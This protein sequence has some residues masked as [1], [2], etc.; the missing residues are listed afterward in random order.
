MKQPAVKISIVALAFLVLVSMASTPSY[1]GGENRTGTNAAPELLI[2]VGAR[3]I[4]M[5]GASIA[6]SSGLDAIFWN[7]AGLARAKNAANAMFSHM[8]Y[9]ADIGVDYVAVSGA[10]EGFGSIGLSIKSLSIGDIKVTTEDAPDGTGQVINPTVV[11]I[12][13]T[14]SRLLTDRI[15]V[16]ATATLISNRFDRVSATGFAFNAGVQYSGLAGVSGLSVGVAVKNVGPQMKFDGEGLLRQGN[17]NDVLRPG[18]F[19][20]VNA[21]SFELPS[22]IEIGLSYGVDVAENNVVNLASV[23]QNNNFA[24]DEYKVGAEYAYDNTFFV[25]GGYNFSEKTKNSSLPVPDQT[26]YI[27]GFTAGAGVHYL[28]GS[29]DL[30]LDYAYR[31]V[32]FLDNNHIFT[33]SLGF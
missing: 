10:F 24:A 14:Y 1:A 16:G 30:T 26:T 7:P 5:G 13:L 4:A 18:S 31:Q 2:P 28:V 25:R 23:F 19:Y 33:L 3:D 17:I 12:G 32:K 15:S 29:L 22:T 21:A 8:N 6:I 27:Y 11:N 9:I 20:Q